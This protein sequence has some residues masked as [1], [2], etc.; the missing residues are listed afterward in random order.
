MEW[1]LRHD[2]S[3][4]GLGTLIKNNLQYEIINLVPFQNGVLEVQTIN[5]HLED[6]MKLSVF[7]YCN[8]NKDVTLTEFQH[9]LKQLQHQHIMV[10]TCGQF[11]K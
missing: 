2:R 7:N 3:D 4:A 10:G 11:F 6:C 8:P 9:Y 1:K 5:L